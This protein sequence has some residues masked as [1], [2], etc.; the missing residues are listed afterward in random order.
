LCVG[1][2]VVAILSSYP[3]PNKVAQFREWR[4]IEELMSEFAAF[5]AKLL[6]I[7]S[8]KIRIHYS[9]N[10]N[11]N[12]HSIQSEKGFYCLLRDDSLHTTML[13]YKRVISKL[14][15]PLIHRFDTTFYWAL[16]ANR[17]GLEQWAM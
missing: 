8:H 6:R 12:I 16:D 15:L 9:I 10:P 7:P 4:R 13:I 2:I 14:N 5:A 17:R 11:R 3:P 1:T